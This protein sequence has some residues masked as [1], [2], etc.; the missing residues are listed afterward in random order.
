MSLVHLPPTAPLEDMIASV[1]ENGHVI[2]DRLASKD[3][4]DAVQAELA[5][6][7]EKTPFVHSDEAGRRTKRTGA[8]VARSPAARSLI[9]HPAVLAM[10]D[11]LIPPMAGYQLS[12]TEVISILPGAKAQ[13]IHQDEVGF[14]AFP[15]PVDYC[16]QVSTLWAMTDY[17]EEMG[18][19]RVVPD[20]HTLERDIKFEQE[21]TVPAEMERGSILIYSGKIYHGGGANRSD[22]VRQ[23]MNINYA[24]AWLRQEENQYLSTPPEIARTLSP[25]LLKLMGYKVLHG[26]LGRVE[27]W[28]DPLSFLLGDPKLVTETEIR[29]GSL[30]VYEKPPELG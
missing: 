11:A 10:C 25:E 27:D 15:F 23:A 1:Q 18:A 20:S 7:I 8:L 12:L 24:A 9:M 14:A 19:T 6:Y 26:H 4:M 21:H 28:I 5:P 3:E 17:T 16:A 22:A 29:E 30:D 13:M 2:V